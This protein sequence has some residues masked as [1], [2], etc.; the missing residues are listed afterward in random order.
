[1]LTDEP[2]VDLMSMDDGL[3]SLQICLSSSESD[4]MPCV[5]YVVI[6]QYGEIE[7]HGETVQLG[8]GR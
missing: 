4:R 5:H 2:V 8:A 6:Q 7:R 3:D 1:M